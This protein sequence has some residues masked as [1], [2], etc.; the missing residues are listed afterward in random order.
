MPTCLKKSGLLDSTPSHTPGRPLAGPPAL[1]CRDLG[2]QA[3]P[4]H[5]SRRQSPK[6][7]RRNG[8]A[9]PGHEARAEAAGLPSPS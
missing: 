4:P 3:G 1:P 9:E 8:D 7:T 5:S 2:G 6:G